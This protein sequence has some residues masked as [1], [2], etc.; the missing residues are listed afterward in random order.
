MTKNPMPTLFSFGKENR[1]I[2]LRTINDDRQS[3]R[4]LFSLWDEYHQFSG[5]L[6]ISFKECT[7][8][9]QNAV[10]FLGGLIATIRNNGGYVTL[11]LE[12]MESNVRANL[13]QNGFL[14]TCGYRDASWRGNSVSFRQDMLSLPPAIIRY[15]KEDWLRRHW[16]LVTTR[17]QDAVAGA[18]WEIYANAFE[19]SHS[20][21]GVFSCGQHYPQKQELALAIVDF[22]VSIP[23][24]VRNYARKHGRDPD[25]I[26]SSTA[27]KWAFTSGQSTKEDGDARGV[28]LDILKQFIQVNKGNLELYS[29]DGYVR[30][31]S[32]REEYQDVDTTFIGTF[33]NISLKCDENIYHF[34]DETVCGN[35]F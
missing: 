24:N 11:D 7:F 1:T 28:G 17:L 21:V 3:Y 18:V 22:G 16:L 10:A 34:S 14:E 13:A 33:L 30:I 23:H 12:S 15:L 29:G 4:Y 25:A 8:L 9:R 6:T 31:T 26:T 27:L 20:S 5:S 35:L 2:F 19:H 32:D